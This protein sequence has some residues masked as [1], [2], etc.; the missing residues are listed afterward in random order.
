MNIIYNH[1]MHIIFI[2]C[3]ITK[4]LYT[5][6]MNIDWQVK[7]TKIL[8]IVLKQLYQHNM[9]KKFIT[10]IYNRITSKLLSLPMTLFFLSTFID[11]VGTFFYFIDHNEFIMF[12]FYMMIVFPYLIY[13]IHLDYCIENL[14]KQIIDML[15]RKNFTRKNMFI[16]GNIDYHRGNDNNDN[17]NHQR[18]QQTNRKQKN[19]MIKI[20]LKNQKKKFFLKQMYIMEFGYVYLNDFHLNIY[21]LFQ[22]DLKFFL[23]YT[24]SLIAYMVISIQTSDEYSSN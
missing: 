4:Q 16:I 13:I 6:M 23:L 17:S 2:Y 12:I 18:Q 21:H 5:A 14:F 1:L 7:R 15:C 11:V 24:L 3:S 10:T 20:S 9:N 22:I 8:L 19:S